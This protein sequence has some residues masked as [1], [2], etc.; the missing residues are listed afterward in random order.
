M[1][2]SASEN[3]LNESSVA[4]ERQRPE[5]YKL[6]TNLINP[7]QRAKHWKVHYKTLKAR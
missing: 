1:Q 5:L 2:G 3:G 7:T 6:L 4:T